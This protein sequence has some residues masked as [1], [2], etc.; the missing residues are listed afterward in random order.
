MLKKPISQPARSRD[1]KK[2]CTRLSLSDAQA[3]PF[4]GEA[5]Q[6]AGHLFAHDLKLGHL[7]V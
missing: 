5:L 1:I 6:D 2:A 4:A 3:I 7:W